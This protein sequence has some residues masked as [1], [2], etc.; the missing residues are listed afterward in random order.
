[1]LFAAAVAGAALVLASPSVSAADNFHVEVNSILGHVSGTN[2]AIL[3]VD[4]PVG[5]AFGSFRADSLFGYLAYSGTGT[6]NRFALNA[7]GS[8]WYQD[9]LTIFNPA[10]PTAQTGILNAAIRADEFDSLSGGCNGPACAGSNNSWTIAVD[11]GTTFTG[12]NSGG[13]RTEF[14]SR[15]FPITRTFTFGV[16]FTLRVTMTADA[17]FSPGG[18]PGFTM[19]TA[20]FLFTDR[21]WWQGISSVTDALGHP[22]SFTITPGSHVDWRVPAVVPEPSAFALSLVGL[23]ALIAVRRRK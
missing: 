16:P 22:V 13:P 3:N 18:P 7:T 9:T 23:V 8:G 21:F 4:S 2:T 1:L 20:N 12:G 5:G 14:S 15:L 11:G 6:A 19:P 10:D 17:G